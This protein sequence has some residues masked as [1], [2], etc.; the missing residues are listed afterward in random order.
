MAT[1]N[2]IGQRKIVACI[3]Q[4][5]ERKAMQHPLDG[6]LPLCLIRFH[7][8]QFTAK[9]QRA[10]RYA[11]GHGN[12]LAQIQHMRGNIRGLALQGLHLRGCAGKRRF[13]V[14]LVDHQL[15]ALFADFT[16]ATLPAF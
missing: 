2:V 1:V 13:G 5:R 11:D 8:D 3:D 9:G 6:A 4:Q 10:L 15:I 16:T 7:L 14:F 12:L